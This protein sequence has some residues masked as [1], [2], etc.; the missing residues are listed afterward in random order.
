[1]KQ[2]NGSSMW[3]PRYFR[4]E[5]NRLTYYETKSLVGTRNNKVCGWINSVI[6]LTSRRNTA[7]HIL[8]RRGGGASERPQ[9]DFL[10]T[11]SWAVNIKPR[12]P[13]GRSL[14]VSLYEKTLVGACTCL[15]WVLLPQ[16]PA[17]QGL[18]TEYG[19]VMYVV[20]N[21]T[22]QTPNILRLYH[23]SLPSPPDQRNE[24]V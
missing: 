13:E 20:P 6:W 21:D 3:R 11:R 15:R 18:R 1:M 4:L 10:C 8:L 7:T 23:T 2:V 9:E 14:P 22:I 19:K 16:H 5:E 24:P 17:R 12:C